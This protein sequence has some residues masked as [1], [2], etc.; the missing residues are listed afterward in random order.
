VSVAAEEGQCQAV[1]LLGLGLVVLC[2][3]ILVV[4]LSVGTGLISGMHKDGKEN[5]SICIL[6]FIHFRNPGYSSSYS[7][8]GTCTWTLAKSATN[9][10]QIRLDFD[11]SS[12]SQP[13]NAAGTAG[14]CSTVDYF[15]VG[16]T[17]MSYIFHVHFPQGTPVTGKT[18]PYICGENAGEHIYIDAGAYS[19]SEATFSA[20]LVGTATDRKWKIKVSM[21]ECGSLALPPQ[22]CLQ[23]HTGIAGQVIIRLLFHLHKTLEAKP[24]SRVYPNVFR[25]GHSTLHQT[26]TSTLVTRTIRYRTGHD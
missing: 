16:L 12:I 2:F 20:V 9:I 25:F 3:L 5:L 4:G 18:T 21:I 13:S 14:D 15:R 10:C 6:C 1:V 23:Y 26:T 11:E 17:S 7:T 19:S 8:A 22:G 24:W